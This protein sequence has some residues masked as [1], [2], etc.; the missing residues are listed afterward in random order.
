[1]RNIFFAKD[2][3]TKAILIVAL[4]SGFRALHAEEPRITM[5]RERKSIGEEKPSEI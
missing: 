2:I 5:E 3:W 1:M 4:F